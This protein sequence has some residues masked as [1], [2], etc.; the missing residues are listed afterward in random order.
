M[1][2][3]YYSTHR[4]TNKIG[5]LKRRGPEGWQTLDNELGNFGHALLNT[6][7]EKVQL[8]SQKHHSQQ[9]LNKKMISNDYFDQ[10]IVKKVDSR[11]LD[12]KNRDF[13]HI[14]GR[15]IKIRPVSETLLNLTKQ[16]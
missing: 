16:R 11:F 3:Y 13:I 6:I 15:S 10:E 9:T 5:N 7:G 8:E 2:G 14:W 12:K 1:C 4:H